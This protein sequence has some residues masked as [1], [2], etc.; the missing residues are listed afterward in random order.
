MNLSSDIWVYALIRRVQLGGAFATVVRR[1]DARGGAIL[2]KTIDHRSGAA[3]LYAQAVGSDGESLWMQPVSGAEA[4]LDAYVERAARRDP[5]IWVVEI[6]DQ[7]ARRFLT[8]P[9]DES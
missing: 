9:L 7:D 1:G 4:E 2:V 6:E 5:D 8:E 3:R